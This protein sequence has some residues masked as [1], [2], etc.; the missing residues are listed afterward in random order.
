MRLAPGCVRAARS[1]R[2]GAGWDEGDDPEGRAGERG[3]G[4]GAHGSGVG[5]GAG[6]LGGV[7]R[8]RCSLTGPC[9]GAL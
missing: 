6:V 3:D 2:A 7:V 8:G 9:Q 1:A 5:A 4:M